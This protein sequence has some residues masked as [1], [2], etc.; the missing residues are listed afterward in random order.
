M[1][2]GTMSIAPLPSNL[3]QFGGRRFAFHPPIRD[4]GPNEWLYRRAT[5]S[6][7]IVMNTVTGQEICVPRM[8]IGDVTRQDEPVMLVRLTRE[9][10]WKEGVVAPRETRIIEFPRPLT[11]L[12]A[13]PEKTNAPRKP[14]P[15]VNIRLEPKP[16]VKLWR[17]FGVAAILGVVGFGIVA[18]VTNRTQMRQRQD[19]LRNSRGYLQLTSSDDFASVVR[20][21]GMPTTDRGTTDSTGRVFR[22]LTYSQRR[23]AV[24]LM[25]AAAQNARYIGTIDPRGL[26]LDAVRLPD[27]ASSE[28]LLHSLAAF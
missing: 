2:I 22:A 9:L 3:Q 6:E 11:E 17:W 4:I 20:R 12:E 13:E 21:L 25:G 27:G 7:C 8:F 23:Y 26:V 19:L 14:A 5:W 28:P 10:A 15:V 1:I 18:D 16:D 24:V